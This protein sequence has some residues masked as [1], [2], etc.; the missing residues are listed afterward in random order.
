MVVA[1]KPRKVTFSLE[2]GEVRSSTPMALLG[3]GFSSYVV[4]LFLC[5]FSGPFQIAAPRPSTFAT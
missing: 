1:V 4:K 3:V 5:F 2:G